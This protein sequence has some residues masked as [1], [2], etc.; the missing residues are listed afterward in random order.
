MTTFEMTTDP[1]V[2]FAKGCGRCKKFD[3]PDCAAL[4]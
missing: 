2:Y 4:R 3:S 1:A